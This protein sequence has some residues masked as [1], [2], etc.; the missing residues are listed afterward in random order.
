[1]A[2]TILSVPDISCDHCK[3]TITK[4]LTPVAGVQAVDVDVPAKQVRV[5]YDAS[6]LDVDRLKALLAEEDYPVAAVETPA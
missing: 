3:A 5:D 4:A 1:M 2:R 6:A